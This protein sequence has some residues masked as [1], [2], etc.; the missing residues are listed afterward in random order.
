MDFEGFEPAPEL[1]AYLNIGFPWDELTGDYVPGKDGEEI[2]N[3]GL[4][5]FTG[6]CG[7]GNM[8]KSTLAHSQNLTAINRYGSVKS[9]VYDTEPPSCSYKRFA[10]LMRQ[11]NPEFVA[12]PQLLELKK[13]LLLTDI[14]KMMG[15]EWFAMMQKFRDTKVSNLKKLMLK[16]P[17]LLTDGS[18]L[19]EPMIHTA[20]VDSLSMMSL[21]STM[22][23]L[24][25]NELGDGGAN[26]EAMKT[27]GAKTQMLMQIPQM[28]TEANIFFIM[29]A[30]T[31]KQYQLDPR[32]PPSKQ[33]TFLKQDVKLKNVPEKFTFLP[34]NL[35]HVVKCEVL[36]NRTTKA[37]EY[38]RRPEESNSGNTDLMLLTVINLRGKGGPTGVPLE[39]IVS[40]S[41]GFQPELTALRYLKANEG[42]GM[43]GN[44]KNYFLEFYPD[45]K[46]SRTTVRAK[47]VEDHRLRRALELTGSICQ[48]H[49]YW[50]DARRSI[51]LTPAQIVEK[52]NEL[53]YDWNDLLDTRGFW[54]YDEPGAD[55]RNFMSTKDLLRMAHGTYVPKWYKKPLKVSAATQPV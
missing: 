20:E 8:Y 51:L 2:L 24:E 23:L 36:L 48:M 10:M 30:H 27:Q 1:R 3:G 13:R 22:K 40:Q 35:Y 14:T 37:P 39:L 26:I 29:T 45:C 31:G 4:M 33:M 17:M 42:Y 49:N 43:G 52:I 38:P 53:G 16:T 25:E 54:Q 32:T 19:M 12:D 15:N 18:Q 47:C 5:P 34:N 41:E 28:S 55:P 46:L 44:D 21:E 11:I 6:F 50:H 7:G 9:M